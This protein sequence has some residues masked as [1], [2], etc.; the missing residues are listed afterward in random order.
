MIFIYMSKKLLSLLAEEIKEQGFGRYFKDVTLPSGQKIGD[1]KSV[2]LSKAK[3]IL[4]TTTNN[5]PQ[6]NTNQSTDVISGSYSAAGKY[7]PYDALHSFERRKSDK[8]GGRL[9]TL[10]QEGIQKYKTNN[11]INAVDILNV[12]IKI[13]PETLLVEWSVTIGPSTDGSTY[14]IIDSRGSAG[15]GESAVNGQLQS[16]HNKHTGLTPVLVKYYNETI[17]MYYDVNGNK[18]SN[19]K[20]KINI[21]QKFF[22]YGKV[23]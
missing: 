9:N 5:Q 2:D 17:P 20:G 6:I 22:K 15:G 7:G 1:I 14:E 18:L 16:M 10:V 13:T 4:P 12:D 3:P 8:F 19:S 21:Q 11:N 23:I